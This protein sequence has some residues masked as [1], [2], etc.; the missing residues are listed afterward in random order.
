MPL[1]GLGTWKATEGQVYEAVSEALRL[2]YRHIDCAAIY[3][4]E[5]EIGQAFADAFEAGILQRSDLWVTSKLWNNS[6]RQQQVQPALGQTLRDLRLDYLDLYLV[7]WPIALQAGV[8]FPAS[9]NDYLS[10]EEVPLAETWKGMED[11]LSTGLVRHIGV[12]NFSVKKLKDMKA[13]AVH[14]P[15]MNQVEMHPFLQQKE[16][17]SY[18]QAQGIGLTAYSPLGSTDRPERLKKEDDPNLLTHPVILQIA[19][20]HGCTAAQVLLAWGMARQV[21]VIPKSVRPERLK[22]NLDAQYLALSAENM[23]AI[24]T[25]DLHFRFINGRTWAMPGAP[26]KIEDIWDE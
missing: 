4:N 13:Y 12:S 8:G 6:H 16:L 18:C 7:H 10:L 24:A 17:Y 21:A 11:L 20:Q 25:L 3:G 1:L 22:I 2:G 14:Q 26:Y 5:A 9:P 23:E 15:E 19:E